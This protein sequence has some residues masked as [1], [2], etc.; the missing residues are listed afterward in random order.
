VNAPSVSI[1]KAPLPDKLNREFQGSKTMLSWRNKL[2]FAPFIFGGVVLFI[3]TVFYIIGGA[4][5]SQMADMIIPVSFVLGFIGLIFIGIVF[6]QVR[7]MIKNA[8][9]TFRISID[10][11]TFEYA[12]LDNSGQVR[13]SK[14]TPLKDVYSIVFSHKSSEKNAP[15]Y[16]FT[17][18]Q[19]EKYLRVKSN[20]MESIRDLFGM[21]AEN[22]QLNIEGLNAVECLQLEN[23]LQELIKIQ[24]EKEV[25]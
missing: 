14:I 6:V 15:L 5:F 23:W 24:A 7:K 17:K 16:I 1:P 8:T 22:T 13:L 10:K 20:P 25:I 19:A 18:E 11:T 21:A 3:G 9:T 12:E 2:G 4:V